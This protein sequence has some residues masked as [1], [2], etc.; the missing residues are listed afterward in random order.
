[1]KH[2][3]RYLAL[4]AALLAV[5]GAAAAY[6]FTLRPPP[7]PVELSVYSWP[8]YIP[9][10]LFERFTEETGI[11]IALFTYDTNEELREALA[12]G[13]LYDIALPSDFMVAEL[14]EADL[15]LPLKR[16]EMPN[17]A[18][19]EAPHDDP[20]FDPGRRYSTPYLWGTIGFTY[21]A[22]R[23]SEPL[24]ESWSEFFEP[25]TELD[26][27]VA[28]LGDEIEVYSAAAYY[29]DID[30]CTT[31]PDSARRILELL[32]AQK[33]HLAAYQSEGT[34]ESMVTGE[35][36]LHHQW[37]GAA[38]RTRE[39]LGTA[40]YV[41]PREG[42]TYW[43]DNF[44]IPAKATHPEPAMRFLNWMMQ[45]ENS[46]EASNFTGYMNAIA[47]SEEFLEPALL[48]DP[49]VNPP[50]EAMARLRPARRCSQE[51]RSLRQE[52]WNRLLEGD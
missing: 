15:L 49:A 50:D 30:R 6:V 13:A 40:V 27:K 17:L 52:V 39:S 34:I 11:E 1:M 42:V 33:P 26:G 22:A 18:K 46:A 37:N 12:A 2:R 43:Q 20:V 45:P 35:V 21:D 19:I 7:E 32:E 16:E 48:E 8:N 14:I 29:L 44:V 9:E 28:A 41:Y 25:R 4:V 10:A 23:T 38:H 3:N 31:D 47:G 36:I 5:A 24:K 51:A